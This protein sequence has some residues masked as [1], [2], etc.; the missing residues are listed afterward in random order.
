M[1]EYMKRWVLLICALCFLGGW[2]PAQQTTAD[3]YGTVVLADGS[4]LP[5]VKV[6][7]SGDVLGAQATV[8]SGEGNFR[9]L[10][11]L[12]STYDLRLEL[13]GF[14]TVI[15]KGI[16]VY[17][18]RNVTLSIPM[19]TSDIKEEVTVE[20][21]APAIDTR[22]TSV[23]LTITKEALQS[24]PSSRNPW[25]VITMAPGVMNDA[26][27]VG[28]SESAQQSHPNA[29][30]SDYADTV[31]NVD[32]IDNSS[33]A[34]VGTS[35]GYLDVN[36]YEEMQVT[37][38]ASDITAQTGGVQINFVS[39]R[40]GNKLTGDM[41]FY[42]EDKALEMKHDAPAAPPVSN[43]VTP[44]IN[45]LYQYGLSLGGPIQKDKMW[46]FGTWSAQDIHVRSMTG[47]EASYL[48]TNGYGKFN[49]QFKDTAVE[50]SFSYDR[51]LNNAYLP[52]SSFSISNVTPDAWRK[53]TMP[54]YYYYGTLQQ[55]LGTLML[56][57]KVGIIH[58]A[59][60]FEPAN[61]EIDPVSGHQIG[62]DA[63]RYSK[64]FI[65]ASGSA[66]NWTGYLDQA[67]IELEGNLFKEKLLGGDH[68]LRFGAEYNSISAL[69]ETLHPN[70]R[71]LYVK[72]YG[73]FTSSYGI[74]MQP[75]NKI[76]TFF[77]RISAYLS[78]TA[79]YKRFTL[80]VGLRYDLQAPRIN[81]TDLPGY[82]WVDKIDASHNG[83]A[84]F[85]EFLGPM[86]IEEFSPPSFNTI[87]PRFS[88]TYDI[89][90]DGKNVLK[91][92]AARYGSRGGL[93]NMVYPLLPGGGGGR[94]I[95]VYWYDNGDGIPT[96]NELDA[97]E[98]GFAY[99]YANYCLD[100]NY[101]TGR[102]NARFADD[103]NTPLLDE[104]T[105]SFEKQLAEDLAVSVTGFYK[106]QHNA[107]R[108]IGIMED[109]SIETK[110]NWYL[111]STQMVNGQ[112]VE[113]WDR[114]AVPV[115]TYYTNYGSGTYSRYMALQFAMTKKFSKNWMAD[116]SFMFQDWKQFNDKAE[117]FNM[118][119]HD[120]FDGGPYYSHNLRGA[121]DVYVNSRWQFKLSG[122]YQL[123][124]GINVS[125]FFSLQEGY[126]IGDYV[127]SAKKLKG[128]TY[129]NLFDPTQKFGENRLPA[130][131]TLNMGVEKKFMIGANGRTSVTVFVDAY[132]LTNNATVLAKGAQIG[133]PSFGLVT[134]QLNPGIF[135]LGAR[136]HF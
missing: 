52:K 50:L 12:P 15:R 97:P 11:L 133:T 81:K 16:R 82:T 73:D 35:T 14:K 102:L 95:D 24:L 31:W 42:L 55:V 93:S 1:E 106:K 87:S 79:T 117:T 27:D 98:Y 107:L 83:Y 77:K 128:G 121:A 69:S 109:G 135:Q 59:F 108:E 46:W 26:A 21:K 66:N 90:G 6:T 44:G 38:G 123:P 13:E 84:F 4:V 96:W 104:L 62:A 132:N 134:N 22:R 136:F 56:N 2:L 76:D 65:K 105:L 18:G 23:G 130:F 89:S 113:V 70:Q 41:H 7:I 88:L 37:T 99:A 30:G 94:E 8:T 131:W 10:R 34:T 25:S 45:K 17:A 9:F 118:T 57:A 53:Q 71:T 67:V 86:T 61:L 125:A 64:S 20:A 85:P 114:Y 43:Y 119:N 112:P 49:G 72:Y 103:Y 126:I 33:M 28:G 116:A 51:K 78:D 115:G 36:N 120:F 3:I 19:E 54:N 124:W 101:K 111:K 68:E 91:F 74:W 32:G 47:D 75:D 92:S 29:G 60:S 63:V 110:A 122:L 80:N 127:Q 40:G 129:Q 48:L 39:K 58:Q 100:I 5:G